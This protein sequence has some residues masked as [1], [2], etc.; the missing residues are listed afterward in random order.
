LAWLLESLQDTLKSLKSGLEECYALLAPIEP[1]S[2]LAVSSARSESVKGH[3][4]RV[5]T[6][7]VKGVRSLY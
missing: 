5:G 4:T 3:I 7:I 6:N 2:T 1:G